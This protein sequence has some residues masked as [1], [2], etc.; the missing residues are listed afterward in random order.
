MGAL[1]EAARG[2]GCDA[3]HPGY[4]FLSERPELAEAC[5]EHGITFVGPSP[6]AIRGMGNKLAAREL[7]QRL[8]V[9]TVPGSPRVKDHNHAG[10]L[11][12]QVG[13]PV[14]LKAA[15]GGGGRGI[16]IALNPALLRGA[17]ETASAEARAAF[18]D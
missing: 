18:G 17:L 4:G 1:I 3:L 15:G 11:A 16:K 14:L 5:A 2:T 9:P 12:A 7:A 13:Y 6:Q 10:E 8:G